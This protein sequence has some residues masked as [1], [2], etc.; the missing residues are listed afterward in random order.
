MPP[1]PV[2]CDA[3]ADQRFRDKVREL[4]PRSYNF[5]EHYVDHELAHI[6]KVFST[7]LCPV[8]DKRV[9]EF[10][11]NVGATAIVLAHYGAT[12]V[13][14]DVSPEYVELAKLN[15]QRYG[16]SDGIEYCALGPGEPLPIADNSFD[17]VTCNS[18]L[19]YVSPELLAGVQREIDRVLR[20]GGLLLV[21][22][23]SNRLWPVESHS[24]RWFVNYIPRAF[25]R[26]LQGAPERGV[27]PGRLRWGFGRGY[28]DVL[29][30]W[31]GARTYA[32]L[33]RQM[34]ASGWRLAVMRFAAAGLALSP[35]SLGLMMPYATVLL[36]KRS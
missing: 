25:D 17:V 28:D 15:A 22:G 9:F 23:T 1:F 33:K 20:P 5:E 35:W 30:G 16:I 27:W 3:T 36:R 34:G 13:A 32:E 11:C 12:V 8:R 6:G 31:K 14:V 18:V 7:E 4:F 29:A 19:E 21:F 10:G 26:L 2:I 24:R